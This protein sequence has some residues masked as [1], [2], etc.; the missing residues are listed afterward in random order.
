M[1]KYLPVTATQ[2]ADNAIG[3]AKAGA[4]ILHLHARDPDTGQPSAKPEHFMGF[5]PRI[6]QVC[7]AVVNL[8]TGGS[9]I[10]PLNERLSGPITAAPEMC[11]LNMGSMN[12]AL[13]P[14]APRYE[15]WQH[16]W[17]KPF[18]EGTDDLVFKNTPRDIA[19]VI[20]EMGEKRG[21]R[22]E[23]ECYDMGH[24]YMLRHFVDRGLVKAPL[25]IQFVFGVLGGMGADPENLIHMK[26]LADKLF[27]DDYQWSVLAAGRNQMPF[28]SIA[29]SMGGHV[30][31][32]LEDSLMISRGTLAKSNAEQVTKAREIAERLGRVVATPGEAREI[33][34]LK[35]ADK[36]AF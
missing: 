33:L 36:T 19:H 11:S 32:G 28:V 10:M 3:A 2:I 15:N 7:D 35:G 14:M 21:A 31:V 1:S 6:K 20:G 12:F 18:L 29:A 34:A 23:F 8:T 25:F 26:G 5:L 4:A 27:A 24:L 22:F 30:R 17:E 16:D 9:A 13:Y